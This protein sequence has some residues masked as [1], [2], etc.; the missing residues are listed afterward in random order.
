MSRKWVLVPWEKHQ[1]GLGE[2]KIEDSAEA[3]LPT[4][5]VLAGVPKLYKRQA[6][7]LIQHIEHTAKIA[8]NAQGEVILNGTVIL[9]SHITD[10]LKDTFRKY[11]NF[12]PKGVEQ[13]YKTLAESNIPKGLIGNFERRALLVENS[14]PPG[15]PDNAWLSWK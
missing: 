11:K 7:A 1:K 15:V 4:E 13:F 5:L 10:L 3:K 6:I 12:N 9:G 8:W 14:K 2:E